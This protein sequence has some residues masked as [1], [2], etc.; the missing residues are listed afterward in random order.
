M[1]KAMKKLRRNFQKYDIIVEIHDARIPFSGRNPQFYSV[2]K[3]KPYILLLSKIDQT[4]FEHDLEYQDKIRQRL[5]R[6]FGVG[7]IN[8]FEI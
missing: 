5:L 6:S 4:P 1:M 2:F 3:G 8:C 7:Q